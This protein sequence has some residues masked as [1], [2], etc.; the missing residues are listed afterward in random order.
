METT[1]EKGLEATLNNSSG[2][3]LLKA[4][5]EYVRDRVKDK[6]QR[7]NIV[8]EKDNG[9]L[10][11]DGT[12]IRYHLVKTITKRGDTEDK[13]I[14]TARYFEPCNRLDVK[15]KDADV[16][17]A[18]QE[19]TRLTNGEVRTEISRDYENFYP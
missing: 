14:V 9:F 1:A 16:I 8:K 19:V 3:E 11:W 5:L 6:Y 15:T 2:N 13:E 7:L 12:I 17:R 18:C 4:S 10:P